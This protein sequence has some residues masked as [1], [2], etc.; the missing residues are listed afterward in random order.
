[1]LHLPFCSLRHLPSAINS[2]VI[3][4]L[5]IKVWY[6]HNVFWGFVD[7][8]FKFVLFFSAKESLIMQLK[9]LSVINGKNCLLH[10][11]RL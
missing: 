5:L 7:S 11:C 8:Q 1:M 6:S 2:Y 10:T 3:V 9:G 4:A